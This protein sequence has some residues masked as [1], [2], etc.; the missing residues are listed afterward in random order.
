[1]IVRVTA[2]LL[3]LVVGGL[4][5]WSLAWGGRT[6]KRVVGVCLIIGAILWV[7]IWLF[8]AAW[9]GASADIRLWAV[10]CALLAVGVL[11]F[12]VGLFLM[13]LRRPRKYD[14]LVWSAVVV[15]PLVLFLVVF[16]DNRGAARVNSAVSRSYE[17]LRN[18]TFV[19]IYTLC[20]YA[21][22]DPDGSESWSCEVEPYHERVRQCEAEVRRRSLWRISVQLKSCVARD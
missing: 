12:L 13:L 21:A 11:I 4:I 1:M 18:T 2:A 5:V 10:F 9:V 15:I 16:Q 8:A 19:E 22:V 7:P 20:E 17:E 6:A 3:C 14:W